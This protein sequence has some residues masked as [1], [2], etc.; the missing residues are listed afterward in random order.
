MDS[1]HAHSGRGSAE[2]PLCTGSGPIWVSASPAGKWVLVSTEEDLFPFAPP[3]GPA[4]HNTPA[5]PRPQPP[6]ALLIHQPAF[7]LVPEA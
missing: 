3:L 2:G 5:T 7:A 1:T 6:L 4:P